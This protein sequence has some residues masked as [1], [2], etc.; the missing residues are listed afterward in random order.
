MLSE[1]RRGEPAVSERRTQ[2]R[3]QAPLWTALEHGPSMCKA[4]GFVRSV[5]LFSWREAAWR[6]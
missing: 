5:G 1:A 6:V 3:G 2:N 4:L